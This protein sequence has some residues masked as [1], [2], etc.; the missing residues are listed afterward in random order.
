MAW[1]GAIYVVVMWVAA[2][3]YKVPHADYVVS[4][5]A[6]GNA[7]AITGLSLV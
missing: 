7:N 6:A 3:A 1:L 2:L 5:S 4:M